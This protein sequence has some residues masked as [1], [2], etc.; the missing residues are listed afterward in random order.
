MRCCIGD[1]KWCDALCSGGIVYGDFSKSPY[2]YNLDDP[3]TIYAPNSGYINHFYRDRSGPRKEEQMA[4]KT[5]ETTK[6]AEAKAAKAKK[7]KEAKVRKAYFLTVDIFFTNDLLGTNPNDPE[8]YSKY[9]ADLATDEDRKAEVERIGAMEVDEKGMTVFVRN[10]DEPSIPQLKSYTWLGFVKERAKGLNGV[11]G[12]VADGMKAF[13]KEVNLR[14][15]VS[16]KFID[17][18]LPEGEAI[19]VL[20]RPLRA[21]GPSGERT[22]LAKSEVIPAGSK[23]RLTFRCETKEGLALVIECLNEGKI[24]GTGQWRNAGGDHADVWEELM[25]LD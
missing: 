15:A 2:I 19:G 14:V 12:T 25:A 22:A 6:A 18:I 17:V 10:P 9:I 7:E 5:T 1:V 3:E 4:T 20:E 8:I 24:H 16:P 11:S 13:I 21:S 23:C